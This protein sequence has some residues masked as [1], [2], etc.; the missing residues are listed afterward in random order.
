MRELVER[1]IND[2]RVQLLFDAYQA[3]SGVICGACQDSFTSVLLA[4]LCKR[5]GDEKP[6][7]IVSNDC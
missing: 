1:Y 4:A 7:L 6:A 2:S 5:L 3:R